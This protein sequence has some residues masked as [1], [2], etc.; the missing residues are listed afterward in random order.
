MWKFCHYK[1]WWSN[2]SK[3]G[4]H[5]EINPNVT[6]ITVPACVTCNIHQSR[7]VASIIEN[8]Y[9]L[10]FLLELFKM[11]DNMQ[12]GAQQ[13]AER[14]QSLRKA[15]E[16]VRG[17]W[18]WLRR[19]YEWKAGVIFHMNMERTDSIWGMLTSQDTF[20][21]PIGLSFYK[22]T[23]S[24]VPTGKRKNKTLWWQ[25]SCYPYLFFSLTARAFWCINFGHSGANGEYTF[26]WFYVE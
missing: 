14:I 25:Y 16:T 20:R 23:W 8:K 1:C 18:G 9:N 21:K 24:V 12:S 11:K 5:Y 10:L 6:L 13:R 19:N 3:R 7:L 4:R 2:T 22:G 26:N 17:P 15:E